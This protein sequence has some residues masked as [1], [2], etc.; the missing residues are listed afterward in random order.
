MTQKIHTC[1]L[2][3]AACGILVTV[4]QGRVTRV[5]GDPDDPL[6]RG[7][8]CPKAAALAD[9]QHDPDRLTH[10]VRRT[11]DGW[12]RV[13]WD[14]AMQ[15]V[16]TRLHEI[17]R[18]HSPD[19]VAT[20]LGNPN[21]HNLGSMLYMPG[22]LRALR[23]RR[24]YSAT[25]VDQLPHMLAALQMFGHPL[26][27]PVPDVDRCDFLLMFG[28]N[29]AVSNGSIAT[30]PGI[31]RRLKDVTA[32]GEL[33]VFDPRRTRTAKLATAHHFIRP[34]TDALVLL[35][36]L[37]VVFEERSPNLAHL[38]E[39]A[40]NLERLRAVAARFTPERVAETTGVPAQTI[41]TLALKLADTERALAYGRMGAC[42]QDFGGTT[43]M[44]LV[45]L[46]AVTGHLDTVGGM[47]FTQPAIDAIH[48]PTGKP[49]R[50]KARFGRW[51]SRVRELPEC[52]GELPVATLAED[53]LE[54]GDDRIRALVLWAGNPVLS[55]PNGTKLDQAFDALDFCV[56]VDLYINESNRHADLILP[57]VPPLS[58]PHY[59]TAFA[60]LSVRNFAKF[61]DAA[62]PVEGEERH[63]WEVAVELQQR[64]EALGGVSRS[65]RLATRASGALGPQGTLA[66]ALRVGPRGLQTGL[67]GLSL[68]KLKH[69]PHGL[70]L[71]PLEPCL[72]QRMPTDWPGVDLCPDV[73]TEGLDRLED[74][75]DS[76]APPLV[77]IGRRQL[78]SNNSW[79]HNTK[80]LTKGPSGCT[81]LMHPDDAS[82]AGISDGDTI[83][84]RSA[85]GTVCAPAKLTDEIMRGVISLPHGYGHSRDGVGWQHAAAN[86]G[87]SIN[88]LTDDARVDVVS[89]NA[90]FS[91]TPVEVSPAQR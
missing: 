78:A 65:R 15:E 73:Y 61:V 62:L 52:N 76:P 53:I 74:A 67:G 69:H 45:A 91:G 71:G 89:G 79:L 64:L 34:G 51:T 19:A 7:H 5:E 70:D 29:P 22:L 88:D 32:R 26:L 86:P 77:L 21:V 12:E 16:A 8:I 68:R 90:A 9:L 3:E 4:D 31:R 81:A 42:T 58:R 28:A 17:Q 56:S 13:S 75:V 85:V 6:S 55:C 80:R 1:T 37:A 59:D 49:G 10:P 24:R 72:R 20:Y 63:D 50:A 27:M 48:T 43:G 84:V 38:G 41:R 54:P 33:H 36:M 40:R 60:L 11:A 23:S 57:V 30:A 46:N 25:S 35:A 87:C 66:A 83:E 47:M 44:L 2:C 14:D 18:E 82:T 39:G